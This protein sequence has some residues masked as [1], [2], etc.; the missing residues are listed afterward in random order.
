MER[1][2]GGEGDDFITILLKTLVYYKR[3]A[4]ARISLHSCVLVWYKKGG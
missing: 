2:G 1:V 4:G 3:P